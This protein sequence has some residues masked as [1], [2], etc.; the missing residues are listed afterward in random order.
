M[1]KLFAFL[2][3]LTFILF[4]YHAQAALLDCGEEE[5][6]ADVVISNVGCIGECKNYRVFSR[7]INLINVKVR[8]DQ[9]ATTTVKDSCQENNNCSVIQVDYFPV[10]SGGSV[11]NLFIS[12]NAT[13]SEPVETTSI[14]VPEPVRASMIRVEKKFDQDTF[15]FEIKVVPKSWL[16]RGVNY[17]KKEVELFVMGGI[18]V[19][20]GVGIIIFVLKKKVS[21]V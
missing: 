1:K 3:F 9:T 21:K 14:S 17:V 2:P 5:I 6:T 13:S 12:K 16:V 11:I 7:N 18:A 20:V 8:D 15:S 19:L 4:P 10:C